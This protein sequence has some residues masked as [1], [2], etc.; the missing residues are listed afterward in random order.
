MN[1]CS[2]G[3]DEICYEGNICPLCDTI[4]DFTDQIEVLEE[5]VNTLESDIG[6]LQ[7]QLDDII[8]RDS[9]GS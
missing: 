6:N 9:N 8:A 7:S 3:H 5:Y 2:S 1:L 4:N